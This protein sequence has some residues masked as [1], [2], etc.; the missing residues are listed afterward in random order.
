MD[1]QFQRVEAYTAGEEV[2][3]ALTA[4]SGRLSGKGSRKEMGVGCGQFLAP[5]L[6]SW[7]NQIEMELA[8]VTPNLTRISLWLC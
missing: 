2:E 7:H 3:T 5:S 8:V 4:L 1:T 6:S